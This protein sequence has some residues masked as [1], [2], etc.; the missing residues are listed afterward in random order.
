MTGH[1]LY[2][3][4]PEDPYEDRLRFAA[5]LAIC[6][7]L[8]LL[9]MVPIVLALLVVALSSWLILGLRREPL[10]E[11]RPYDWEVDGYVH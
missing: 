8:A 1:R 11:V 5:S 10:P 3:Q 7:V 4:M 6:I 2:I 9:V